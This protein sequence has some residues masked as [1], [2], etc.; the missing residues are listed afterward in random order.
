MSPIGDLISSW[1]RPANKPGPA[2]SFDAATE[3][4]RT[5][6][7]RLDHQGVRLGLAEVE[8][9]KEYWRLIEAKWY[10][11]TES[12]L[13]GGDHHIYVRIL[14]AEGNPLQGVKFHVIE[15]GLSYDV[16]QD[17]G[18]IDNYRKDV[19]MW[20]MLGTYTVFVVEDGLP[21]DYVEGMGM[22]NVDIPGYKLHTSFDL[23]FQRSRYGEVPPVE[24]TLE[25]TIKEAGQPLIIP[26]NKDAMFWKY[27][28]QNQL[29]ERLTK[30]YDVT[31]K[32]K[33]YRAQIYESGVVY[34]PIGEWDKVSHFERVN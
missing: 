11:Q 28:R 18:A 10:D 1:F 24:K 3:A 23:V 7:S 12:H 8:E 31:Y 19:P 21:S 29:G 22:G 20:H 27:A 17:K 25:E 5:W 13:A 32:G 15:G 4:E 14:D 33:Q 16:V 26:L 6:D 34:A 9:G 2:V 30:E